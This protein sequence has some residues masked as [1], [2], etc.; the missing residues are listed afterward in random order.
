MTVLWIL[1]LT[2]NSHCVCVWVVFCN[3]EFRICVALM[4][5]FYC[6]S[7]N[8]LFFTMSLQKYHCYWG[9]KME[10]TVVLCP[11]SLWVHSLFC[12]HAACVYMCFAF[13]VFILKSKRDFIV[14]LEKNV[15]CLGLIANISNRRGILLSHCVFY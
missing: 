4:C 7:L 3:S 14:Q 13:I 2:Q 11:I 6:I 15:K 1:I 10:K 5:G 12:L 9:F 8:R